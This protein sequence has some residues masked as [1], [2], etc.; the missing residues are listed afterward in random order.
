MNSHN[1]FVAAWAVAGA[2]CSLVELQVA[3]VVK[4]L[5]VGSGKQQHLGHVG[6]IML[7]L[8]KG[9]VHCSHTPEQRHRCLMANT[10]MSLT[11]ISHSTCFEVLKENVIGVGTLNVLLLVAYNI[12]SHLQPH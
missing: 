6:N 10:P 12:S 1:R 2:H 8:G 11:Q 7:L 4:M 3:Q 5:L 9:A